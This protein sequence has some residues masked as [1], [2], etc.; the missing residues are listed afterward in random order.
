RVISSKADAQALHVSWVSVQRA[1]DGPGTL[2]LVVVQDF[3]QVMERERLARTWGLGLL[4]L[5]AG[6]ASLLTA[7][8]ARVTSRDWVQELGRALRGE[9]ERGTPRSPLLEDVRVL[10]QRRAADAAAESAGAG[11]WTQQRL[12]SAMVE[13]LDESGLIIVAN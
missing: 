7:V 10:A 1:G 4:A 11:R 8:A 9:P 13:Q 6:A 2:A 12:R 3:S 5:V